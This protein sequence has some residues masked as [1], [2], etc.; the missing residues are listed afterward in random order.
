MAE[1]IIYVNDTETTGKEPKE[2]DII[3]ISFLR[4]YFNKPDE[5]DQKTWLIRAMNPASIKDDALAKNGHKKEDILCQT[6][7]GRENYKHPNI[8]LPEIE[9][10]IDQDGHSAYDRVFAGQNPKFDWNFELDLW[11]RN[12]SLDTFPFETGPN[13]KI[14]DT[15]EIVLLIDIV[16]G[17][18][19]AS[20]SLSNL[21]KD[22]GIKKEKA[23]QAAGD[24]KMTKDLLVTLTNGFKESVEKSFKK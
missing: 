2:N 13:M 11:S 19:R 24:T 1:Y 17:Q 5:V 14:I 6:E 3:E 10:W 8:V 20:Y 12:N 7:Y 9:A 4:F 21:V 15:K 18:T 22:F 23:H 16:L